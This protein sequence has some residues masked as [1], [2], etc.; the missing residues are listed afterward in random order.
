MRER[1]AYFPSPIV[2]SIIAGTTTRLIQAVK[3][4]DPENLGETMTK[5]H[6]QRVNREKPMS[7]GAAYFCPYGQTDDRLWVRETW[8]SDF[9]NHY[10]HDRFWYAADDDRRHDIEVRGGI[11]GIYSH[12]SAQ[13]VPSGGGQAFRCLA[14]PAGWCSKSPRFV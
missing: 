14:G 8:S 9:A 3:V 2:R 4:I 5:A 10:P 13:F 7:F 6:W 12:E 11:R 1:P